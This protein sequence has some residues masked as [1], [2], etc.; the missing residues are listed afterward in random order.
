MEQNMPFAPQYSKFLPL[1]LINLLHLLI[2][3]L[4][5]EEKKPAS[6]KDVNVVLIANAECF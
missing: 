4:S 6:A 1:K 5:V 3:A 2:N